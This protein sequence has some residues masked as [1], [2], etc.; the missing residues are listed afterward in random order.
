MANPPVDF[1]SSNSKLIFS[2]L[3]KLNASGQP[4]N[5]YVILYQRYEIGSLPAS[6]VFTTQGVVNPLSWTPPDFF[7]PNP[8]T[9]NHLRIT[10]V[11]S[12]LV[13]NPGQVVYITEVYTRHTL[14]T[15][16]SSIGITLPSTLYSVAYF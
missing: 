13:L 6:S 9:D 12:S 15:P 14:V 16:F 7:A 4:N 3:T 1:N 5:G 10:N 11:P 2:V 8:A